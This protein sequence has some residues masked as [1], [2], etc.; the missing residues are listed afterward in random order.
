MFTLISMLI[1]TMQSYTAPLR[2]RLRSDRGLEA[3][4]YAL[5]AALLAAAIV[6]SVTILRPAITTAYQSIANTL[7]SPDV[8]TP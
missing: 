2:T 3:V 1:A 5:L 6:A 4:E 7:G 8:T